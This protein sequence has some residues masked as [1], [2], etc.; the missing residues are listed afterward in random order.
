GGEVA[1]RGGAHCGCLQAVSGSIATANAS[2]SSC[3]RSNHMGSNCRQRR[4]S[5]TTKSGKRMPEMALSAA[6]IGAFVTVSRNETKGSRQRLVNC[7]EIPVIRA[8]NCA[9][10]VPVGQRSSAWTLIKC[11]CAVISSFWWVLGEVLGGAAPSLQT[12]DRNKR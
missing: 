9:V 1:C 11:C 7:G 4:R 10:V 3:A 12:R 2:V 5:C 6:A 8:R